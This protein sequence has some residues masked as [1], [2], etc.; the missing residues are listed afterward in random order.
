[1]HAFIHTSQSMTQ[2]HY[3]STVY[4]VYKWQN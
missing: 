1:M 4:T 3:I 2:I